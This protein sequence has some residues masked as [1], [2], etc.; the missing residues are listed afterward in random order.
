MPLTARVRIHKSYTSSV[1]DKK[2][3]DFI[4]IPTVYK[5][6]EQRARERGKGGGRREKGEGMREKG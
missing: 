1:K 6:K 5:E 2:S 3:T 4:D